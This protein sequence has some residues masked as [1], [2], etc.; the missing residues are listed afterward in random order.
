MAQGKRP[1]RQEQ[2]KTIEGLGV[3]VNG[4]P[5]RTDNFAALPDAAI[6]TLVRTMTRSVDKNAKPVQS[7]GGSVASFFTGGPAP[8]GAKEKLQNILDRAESDA[9][10]TDAN[11]IKGFQ[12]ALS[13]SGYEIDF[14]DKV[15]AREKGYI[16]DF[17]QRLNGGMTLG[18]IAN[19]NFADA[20]ALAT[21]NANRL[22]RERQQRA[23]LEKRQA[24]ERDAGIK[25][26]ETIYNRY[27]SGLVYA[28]YLDPAK[29]A[30]PKAAAT[31]MAYFIVDNTQ[32]GKYTQTRD[33]LFSDVQNGTPSQAAV[34]FLQKHTQGQVVGTRLQADLESNDPTRIKLAQNYMAFDGRDVNATGAVDD[35][36]FKNGQEMIRA[37]LT[38]PPGLVERGEVNI[39][40]LYTMAERGQLYLPADK[41]TEEDRAVLDTLPAAKDRKPDQVFTKEQFLAARLVL[42]NPAGY[43]KILAEENTRR[44][45]LSLN[46]NLEAVSKE[47]VIAS[48]AESTQALQTTD[49]P[50]NLAEAATRYAADNGGAIRVEHIPYVLAQAQGTGTTMQGSIDYSRA[51]GQ[52]AGLDQAKLSESIRLDPASG[53]FKG[54]MNTFLQHAYVLQ[55]ARAGVTM[56]SIPQ[57]VA[58]NLQSVTNSQNIISNTQTDRAIGTLGLPENFISQMR[59][60][61]PDGQLMLVQIPN[62]LRMTDPNGIGQRLPA[63]RDMAAV[64]NSGIEGISGEPAVDTINARDGVVD[65]NDPAQLSIALQ[66]AVAI[67]DGTSIENARKQGMLAPTANAIAQGY[68]GVNVTPVQDQNIE[69][70]PE[71]TPEIKQDKDTPAAKRDGVEV[72]SLTNNFRLRAEGVRIGTGEV[73]PVADNNDRRIAQVAAYN[74]V[75]LG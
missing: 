48:V 74:N 11:E 3:L 7:L 22:E 59:A 15:S 34:E 33:S 46:A 66:T 63:S 12:A 42:D 39:D 6:N 1:S 56:T 13:A 52:M 4:E 47:N 2:L 69:A 62:I 17:R 36:T 58:A 71:T 51:V 55:N 49:L 64:I 65:L 57:E 38:M 40:K 10:L 50:A 31:A 70:S 41:L 32:D 45:D 28:G 27:S 24:A 8:H 37:P 75:G 67:K 53:D 60:N 61:S 73:S 44:A 68:L 5:S 26:Q 72:S 9:G 23:D 19:K 43:E 54:N 29:A 21:E 16:A 30:D 14:D 18:A 20:D 35:V 25:Q